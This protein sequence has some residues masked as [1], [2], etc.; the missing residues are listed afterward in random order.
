MT[1]ASIA[2]I[3]VDPETA[4][5]IDALCQWIQAQT[6]VITRPA[7]VL[8]IA[9]AIGVGVLSANPAPWLEARRRKREAPQ[10]SDVEVGVLLGHI[11]RGRGAD[12]VTLEAELRATGVLPQS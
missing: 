8:R 11:L 2:K 9:A 5:E 10:L 7:T 12:L 1:D 4:A 3:R 6:G